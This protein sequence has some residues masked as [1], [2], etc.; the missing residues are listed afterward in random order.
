M[1]TRTIFILAILILGY[2]LIVVK[3]WQ[4]V[5]FV[6]WQPVFKKALDEQVAAY[7]R[8]YEVGSAVLPELQFNQLSDEG[9]KKIDPKKILEKMIQEKM[10][11]AGVDSLKIKNL[12]KEVE[13]EVNL[14]LNKES[15]DKL[16]K[17]L[18]VIYNWSTDEFKRFYLEPKA[19]KEV[20]AKNLQES[21]QTFGD[22]FSVLTREIKVRVLIPGYRWDAKTGQV[23]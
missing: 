1:R 14:S 21:G 19:L 20:I 6:G 4:P 23:L 22:W 18:K 17:G 9:R 5:A 2:F 13:K 16:E 7:Q 15:Q 12:Q 3:G 10:I 8:A 11:Q